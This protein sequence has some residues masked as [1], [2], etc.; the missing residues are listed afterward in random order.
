MKK[1]LIIIVAVAAVALLVYF[2]APGI[3][4]AQSSP[5]GL[6]TLAPVKS[7]GAIIA[8]SSVIPARDTVLSF[9][10][11]GMVGEVLVKEGDAVQAGQVL[12]RLS[13]TQA[14][15]AD[16][17]GAELEMLTAQQDLDNLN[18]N[19]ALQRS[20]AQQ[21]LADAQKALQDAKN[22]RFAKNLARVSQA[23]IDAAQADLVIA[24]DSLKKAQES[25]DH[26]INR[27]ET[28]IMRAQSLDQ[29]AAAQQRVEKAQYQLQWLIGRPDSIE[30]AQADAKIAVAQAKLDDVQNRFDLL[31]DGPDPQQAALIAARL[32]NAQDKAASAKASLADLE[33]KAPFGGTVSSLNLKAGAFVQ[34]GIE[35]AK[36]ADTS[37]WLVKTKDLTELNVAR[38]QPGMKA[39][40]KLDALPD[41][42]M[43]AQVQ[44]IEDYGQT[45]QSDI[46]YAVVLKLDSP[47]PRLHWNMN[48]TVT[49]AEK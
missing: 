12:A 45:W 27:S 35:V 37:S 30:I 28:D 41:T 15:Q 6:P 26:F 22:D 18:Q 16:L 9:A 3:L 39:T 20:Q 17:S 36:L 2:G 10:A 43:T 7:S 8:E 21:D 40:V 46:V 5:T 33:L 42:P 13:G 32:K 44:Y 24:K 48:A 11:S 31:K 38:I 34:P 23:T 19:A 25:Y 29:L 47:D 14:L 49:F 1:A 4:A